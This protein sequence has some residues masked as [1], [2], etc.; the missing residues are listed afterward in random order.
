M[1]FVARVR[2]MAQDRMDLLAAALCL[3]PTAGFLLAWHMQVDLAAFTAFVTVPALFAL[4]GAEAWMAR[5]QPQLL[6]RLCHGLLGGVA[7]TLAFDALR[8]PLAYLAKGAPDFVP[9]IGQHLVGETIGIAPTAKAML[10]GYGYHYM[11]VGALLG[12]A[13]ALVSGRV[14]RPWGVAAGLGAGLI[15]VSLPQFQLFSVGMGYTLEAAAA[16]TLAGLGL[17]GIVLGTV[18]ERLERRPRLLPVTF[19]REEQVKAK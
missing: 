6:Q 4:M 2:E 17:A 1:T 16:V 10:L 9:L 7:A 15:G 14:R 13:Y 12:A 3:V 11:L 8:L 5:R 18:V 19:L